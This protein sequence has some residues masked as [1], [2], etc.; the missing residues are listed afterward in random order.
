MNQF[1]IWLADLNPQ[2]GTEAGKIRPVVIVQ[3]NFLNEINH[4]STIICPVTTKLHN[5]STILRIRIEKGSCGLIEHS[6]IMVDQIRAIDNS[7]FVKKIG[8]LPNEIKSKIKENI[9]IVLDL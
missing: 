3:T 8:V 6:E 2:I 7:R 4:N 1:E 9:K 5:E